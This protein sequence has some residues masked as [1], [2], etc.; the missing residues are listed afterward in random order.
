MNYSEISF[1]YP[2]NSQSQ[3]GFWSGSL[4]TSAPLSAN[5]ILSDAPSIF[6]DNSSVTS[7]PSTVLSSPLFP[8]IKLINPLDDSLSNAAVWPNVSTHVPFKSQNHQH[9]DRGSLP[10]RVGRFLKHARP[11]TFVDSL[12][13]SSA[14]MVEAIWPLSAVPYKNS[15]G[16]KEIIPLRE[17][18][19][20]TLYR[21]GTSYSTLQVTLYYLILIKPHVLNQ[22]YVIGENSRDNSRLALLCGRRMFVSALILASK[23]LQDRN[24]TAQAW[25]KISGLDVLEINKNEVTF[26][27]AVDWQLHI[28]EAIYQ[29]WA[30]FISKYF[31]MSQLATPV[32]NNARSKSSDWKSIIIGLSP[33]LENLNSVAKPL[34]SPTI[35]A[36]YSSHSN[37]DNMGQ[38]SIRLKAAEPCLTAF[39]FQPVP[40]ILDPISSGHDTNRTVSA[41]GPLPSL[42][43][44]PQNS[45]I[46]TPYKASMGKYGKPEAGNYANP[47]SFIAL[48]LGCSKS[49]TPSE[50]ASRSCSCL[51]STIKQTSALDISLSKHLNLVNSQLNPTPL[52]ISMS[53]MSCSSSTLDTPQLSL[54]YMQSHNRGK[55]LG[56][57]KK[58]LEKSKINMFESTNFCIEA[59][60]KNLMGL[61][62]DSCLGQGKMDSNYC[63]GYREAICPFKLSC[64]YPTTMNYSF[65]SNP[66]SNLSTNIGS[67]RSVHGDLLGE[68]HTLLLSK[69]RSSAD[70]IYSPSINDIGDM[71]Y[72][73]SASDTSAPRKRLCWA[74]E[75]STL[76]NNNL[77]PTLGI[78]RMG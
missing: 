58:E 23:Y 20:E 10:T 4:T 14:N 5:S 35:P 26:L 49:I 54:R 38:K 8:T 69:K 63:T 48:T 60:S 64:Q 59:N 77:H 78:P 33:H 21:S 62:S 55:I 29:R 2:H 65:G 40:K 41:L 6:E 31:S 28:T 46:K 36:P 61:Y 75:A 24:F 44:T 32:T 12:V 7:D 13:D 9:P 39:Q 76:F 30:Q 37:L 70:L 53:P 73:Y 17:F 18:I 57:N 43:L 34:V 50:L 27:L 42:R 3:N 72:K 45:S 67:N 71:K 74:F 47:D 56:L 52:K 22:D 16:Y 51:H 1:Q 25:S 68:S 19:Q 15:F 11:S 66:Y